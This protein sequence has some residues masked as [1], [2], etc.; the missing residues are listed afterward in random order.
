MHSLYSGK[1]LGQWIKTRYSNAV[2]AKTLDSFW[3]ISLSFFCLKYLVN[4]TR[5]YLCFLWEADKLSSFLLPLWISWVFF[6]FFWRASS[7]W[8][9]PARYTIK[10]VLPLV[11][12]PHSLPVWKSVI[13]AVQFG[14][15][16]RAVVV[17]SSISVPSPSVQ[18][19]K[20]KVHS[21]YFFNSIC[22]LQEITKMLIFLTETKCSLP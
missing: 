5:S 7:R 14:T 1:W 11:F 10:Q 6:R 16:C 3:P 15:M 22:R 4:F 9:P 8:F 21:C 19:E 18:Q 13:K 17:L 2:S 20:W 12:S